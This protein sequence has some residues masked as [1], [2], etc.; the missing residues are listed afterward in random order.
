MGNLEWAY[1]PGTLQSPWGPYARQRNSFER[2]V[3]RT[4]RESAA[5]IPW[6]LQFDAQLPMRF[7][8]PFPGK[9]ERL[10]FSVSH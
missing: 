8:S 10:L 5:D 3:S 2:K 7:P 4:R 9:Q 6:A 1:R